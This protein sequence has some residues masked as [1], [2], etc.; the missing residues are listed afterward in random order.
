M[1]YEPFLMFSKNLE[2]DENT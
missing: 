1:T 2:P